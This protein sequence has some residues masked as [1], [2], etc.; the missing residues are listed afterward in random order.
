M[1]LFIKHLIQFFTPIC[2]VL[3][4]FLIVLLVKYDS[5]IDPY[6]AK[7]KKVHPEGLIIGT[8][9][10]AQ[11]LD[12]SVWGNMYNFAFTQAFTPF[13]STYFGLIKRFHPIESQ[14][15]S[16]VLTSPNKNKDK[17]KI[18]LITVDPWSLCSFP[19]D[20]NESGNSSFI[21][22]IEPS[23]MGN[24]NLSYLF[25]YMPT[26]WSEVVRNCFAP[27]RVNDNG[28]Y[29]VSFNY[30]QMQ[31]NFRSNFKEKLIYNKKKE[32]YQSGY[33]SE[34]RLFY[35]NEIVNYLGH[36]G[37][38]VIIQLPVHRELSAIENKFAP[39]FDSIIADYSKKEQ[40]QFINLRNYHD[41]F[42][43]TDGGHIWNGDAQKISKLIKHQ[44]K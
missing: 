20:V 30:E 19:G 3:G 36:D 16:H 31:A 5:K 32:V 23:S 41:S 35:L 9:R 44:M 42:H 40:I 22:Y 27:H 14:N 10:A 11:A 38:V 8:S 6:Y 1:R 28:R 17:Q 33:I 7:I 13:D 18:H 43:Y 34:S 21:N 37:K 12:P 4:A 26:K 39:K 24:V 2:L 15:V 29:V 25:A